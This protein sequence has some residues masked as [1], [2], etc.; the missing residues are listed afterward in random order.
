MVHRVVRSNTCVVYQS[1]YLSSHVDA[2]EEVLVFLIWT[3]PGVLTS[4]SMNGSPNH[5]F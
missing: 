4:T 2:V 5:K 1:A 3:E